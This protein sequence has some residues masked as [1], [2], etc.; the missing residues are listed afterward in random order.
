MDS[1]WHEMIRWATPYNFPGEWSWPN[2]LDTTVSILAILAATSLYGRQSH[3]ARFLAVVACMGVVGLSITAVAAHVPYALLF[4]SQPYRVLWILKALQGPILVAVAGQAWR[5]NIPAARCLAVTCLGYLAIQHFD[6]M[7]LGCVANVFAIATVL[8]RGVR[9]QPRYEHWL[10]SSLAVGVFLGVGGWTALKLSGG[11]FMHQQYLL[12]M[13][14]T[15]YVRIILDQLR[16][17]GWIAIVVPVVT[18]VHRRAISSNRLGWAAICV[19]TV[20][21]ATAFITTVHP[22]VREHTLRFGSEVQFVR[23]YLRDH[24]STGNMPLTIYA[25]WGRL[26]HVWIDLRAKSYFVGEQLVGVLF[27]RGTAVEGR[28]RALVAGPFELDRLKEMEP[29]LP[30]PIRQYFRRRFGANEGRS[31]PKREDLERLCRD[32][33]ADLAILRQEFPGL[34]VA[35]DGRAYIY[36]CRQVRNSM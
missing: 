29:M 23:Q 1:D 15:D 27:N 8:T 16:P 21:Q 2:W 28:R 22:A 25:Y 13:D 7:A 5:T 19:A 30:G 10:T 34:S 35:T 26:D 18:W 20:M 14:T 9:R 24:P 33:I 4:Q 32:G 12:F 3:R 17:L 6:A 11:L 31:H 36:D